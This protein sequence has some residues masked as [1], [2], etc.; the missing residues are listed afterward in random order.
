[1]L[2]GRRL[3]DEVCTAMQA[4]MRADVLGA[5]NSIDG[6]REWIRRYPCPGLE[7]I[8][9]EAMIACIKPGVWQRELDR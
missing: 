1:M 7:Q 4:A 2:A 8:C 3:P 5:E 9:A 6:R